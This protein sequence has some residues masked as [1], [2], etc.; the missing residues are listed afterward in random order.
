MI[1][2]PDIPELPN[3][4]KEAIERDKLV[5]FIGAG[6]S[7]LIG[8]K[9]WIDLG[10][11]LIEKCRK[12]DLI[13]FKELQ[14]IKSRSD[15]KKL[16]SISYELMKSNHE[17]EFYYIFDKA[18]DRDYKKKETQDTYDLLYKLSKTCVTTNA[19]KHFDKKFE[20]QNIVTEFDKTPIKCNFQKLYKIHGTQDRR[21]SL[22]FIAESYIKRYN[23]SNFKKFL[24]DLFNNYVVLF[25]GYG[26]SEFE[27]LDYLMLRQNPDLKNNS[28][29]PKHFALMP[30]YSY[31]E[32]ISRIDSLYYKEL[33][34]QII[35]YAIDTKGYDQLYY[36]IKNWNDKIQQQ[37]LYIKTN[38]ENLDTTLNQM[39]ITSKNINSIIELIKRDIVYFNYFCKICY[40]RKELTNIFIEPLFKITYFSHKNN[41]APEKGKF[42]E[43]TYAIPR[44]Q[45]LDFLDTYV[46]YLKS[47]GDNSK[48][49]IFLKIIDELTKQENHV[50]DND[51]TDSSI[52]TY[53]FNLPVDKIDVHHVQFIRLALS[54]K[55]GSLLASS[56]LY[57]SDFNKILSL[58]PILIEE[59]VNILFDF[60]IYKEYEVVSLV[61]YYYFKEIFAK[62]FIA[63][64][65]KLEHRLIDIVIN[66]INKIPS[67]SFILIQ[68]KSNTNSIPYC[69]DYEYLQTLI[70]T[71]IWL[72]QKQKNPI[73]EIESLIR[74]IDDDHKNILETI[75][76]KV[77]L[78]DKCAEY[79]E[80]DSFAHFEEISSP[81]RFEQLE[82]LS[83]DE[84]LEIIKNDKNK[85]IPLTGLDSDI[86]SLIQK[87]PEKYVN[88]LN[89]FQNIG[90]NYLSQI[91]NA[92]KYLLNQQK[93]Q[94]TKPVIELISN[95]TKR[96]DLWTKKSNT[97][98][99]N[100]QMWLIQ[101]MG[102]YLIAYIEQET[103]NNIKELFMILKNITFMLYKNMS[104]ENNE[105][106]L[107][108]DYI[109][110]LL[111][112]ESGVISQ[113]LI[114]LFLL[115]CRLFGI[116]DRD[117]KIVLQNLI[118][119]NNIV[120]IFTGFGCWFENIL[121]YDDKFAL[122]IIT[123]ITQ[124]EIKLF[125][126]FAKGY[127][128]NR[129]SAITKKSYELIKT[130]GFAE[131]LLFRAEEKKINGFAALIC[132]N[133]LKGYETL[134]EKSSLISKLIDKKNP[135]YYSEIITFIVNN[136]KNLSKK[137][138]SLCLSLWFKMCS[139]LSDKKNDSSYKECII[140]LLELMS[141]LDS[142]TDIATKNIMFSI[143]EIPSYR[144]EHFTLPKFVSLYKSKKNRDNI[145]KLLNEFCNK[146]IYFENYDSKLTELIQMISKQNKA[147]AIEICNKYIQNKN[148]NYE[149]LLK[150]I[151]KENK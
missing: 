18:L 134:S 19:D 41:P 62:N 111:N 76:D 5:I 52:I 94:N 142:M 89:L 84:L 28:K 56:A 130:T 96:T 40:K 144:I 90:F 79:N 3:G 101:A 80:E 88:D 8:C 105:D 110:S 81:Y 112:S 135:I 121:Y 92:Y 143:T 73:S 114:Q 38:I 54:S 29:E 50:I 122:E 118:K 34:V 70:N 138:I 64:Y 16:I 146:N 13:S 57:E 6:V 23:N 147:F 26:L 69:A 86:Y 116:E 148:R 68:F 151:S 131:R 53:I 46:S 149:E 119:Q 97:E 24:E 63:I 31:E 100:Y 87:Y 39:T 127:L 71:L 17:E 108:D 132:R 33:N 128:Y 83:V 109:T 25:I 42:E 91:I 124:S 59:F 141:I 47:S 43:N 75:R 27:L 35:P 66:L 103:D 58:S 125:D 123:T 67:I 21:D 133:F 49:D 32:S 20:H 140:E 145:H 98:G 117:I 78:N 120:M 77:L 60:K 113:L 107:Y 95:L 139:A 4:L 51:K 14:G 10:N 55:W 11:E 150:E 126:A 72:I 82:K 9:R 129:R 12:L 136:K 99:F 93:Y 104:I 36:V 65:K 106:Y 15:G 137:H 44:W 48:S 85:S 45:A 1:E 30:Y 115:S 102:T 37:T 7:T 2:I 61:D 74:I 22:V